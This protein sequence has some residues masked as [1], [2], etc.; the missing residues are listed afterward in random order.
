MNSSPVESVVFMLNILE[1]SLNSTGLFRPPCDYLQAC[2]KKITKHGRCC[3]KQTT[4]D[5]K[6]CGVRG[7]LCWL[8]YMWGHDHATPVFRNK[9][10]YQLK[11]WKFPIPK[12][13]LEN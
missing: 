3:V 1:V 9:T 6:V 10:Q 4:P 7:V 11:C 12:N 2:T 8:I 13:P 5:Q